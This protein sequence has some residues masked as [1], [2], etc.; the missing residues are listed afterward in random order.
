MVNMAQYKG[1]KIIEKMSES[2]SIL[3]CD[4]ERILCMLKECQAKIQQKLRIRQKMLRII[5]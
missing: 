3:V 1:S 4:Y 2:C 5:I